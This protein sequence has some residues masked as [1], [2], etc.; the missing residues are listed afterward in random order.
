MPNHAEKQTEDVL[1]LS[2]KKN[3]RVVVTPEDADRFVLHERDAIAACVNHAQFEV[4]RR[5]ILEKFI[6]MCVE[7]QDWCDQRQSVDRALLDKRDA[8][9]YLLV[10]CTA[11][12]CH[13]F[14]LDDD[15]SAL[16]D[17]LF[18]KYQE[19]PLSVMPIPTDI[20]EGGLSAFIDEKNA[21]SIYARPCESQSGG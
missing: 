9:H 19:F 1:R 13:K 18:N 11:G 7:I 8:H 10:V 20:G 21:L 6:E 2:A 14:D 16:D 5:T 12:D 17:A 15:V 4:L 3:R